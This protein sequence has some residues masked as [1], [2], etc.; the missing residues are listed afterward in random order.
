MYAL[1]L[2]KYGQAFLAPAVGLLRY[3]EGVCTFYHSWTLGG[4]LADA[5]PDGVETTP[6][7]LFNDGW[8]VD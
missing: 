2:K 8:R 5:P 3:E 1:P 4:P 7:A 6:E